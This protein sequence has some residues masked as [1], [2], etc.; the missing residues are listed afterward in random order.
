MTGTYL[1]ES[2][3]PVEVPSLSLNGFYDHSGDWRARHL[4]PLDDLLGRGQT[5]PI[6]LG[7]LA[8]KVLQGVSVAR[9]KGLRE[10]HSGNVNVVQGSGREKISN[11]L[12]IIHA[13]AVIFMA[14]Y[15]CK[16]SVYYS[17]F[18]LIRFDSIFES[19]FSKGF[20][21]LNMYS[22]VRMYVHQSDPRNT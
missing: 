2:F 18:F 14:H 19:M 9:E 7:V 15:Y 22:Y 6:L 20:C 21:C 17:T 12:F 11:H 3:G 4:L 5:F 10:S 8:N 16:S 1:E 13:R